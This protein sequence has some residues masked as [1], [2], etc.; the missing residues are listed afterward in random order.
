MNFRI[1][2]ALAFSC[3]QD[4]IIRRFI[5]RGEVLA[6][7]KPLINYNFRTSGI[8]KMNF[9]S[10]VDAHARFVLQQVDS[11]MLDV[12][13]H[14]ATASVPTAMIPKSSVIAIANSY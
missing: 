11:E 4:G 3:D 6:T 10:D 14:V 13:R 12:I 8:M 5:L 7:I 2:T 9:V 1:N